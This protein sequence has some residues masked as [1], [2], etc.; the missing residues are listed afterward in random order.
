VNV[1]TIAAISSVQRIPDFV[2]D[3]ELTECATCLPLPYCVHALLPVSPIAS[4]QTLHSGQNQ[5]PCF[6]YLAVGAM[7]SGLRRNDAVG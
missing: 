4:S 3:P 7:D 6:R 5:D 1:A 2:V